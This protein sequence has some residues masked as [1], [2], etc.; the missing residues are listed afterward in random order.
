[1][2]NRP[3]EYMNRVDFIYKI[4]SNLLV[5]NLSM[6]YIE[7]E[8]GKIKAFHPVDGKNYQVLQD[9]K[10][11]LYISFQLSNSSNEYLLPYQELIIL[12]KFYY[13]KGL[14]GNSNKVLNDILETQE[15]TNQGIK[16]GIQLS[17]SIKGI[18][19]L[20]GMFNDVD[21]EEYK[22]NFLNSI[23]D[24]TTNKSKGGIAVTDARGEFKETELKPIIL[25]KE[26]MDKVEGDIYKYFGI[27][28]KIIESNFN[29]EQWTSF[30]RSVIEPLS[31]MLS[32][33][34]TNKIFRKESILEGNRIVFTSNL[35]HYSSIENKIKLIKETASLGIFTKDEIRELINYDPLEDKN[36]GSRILQTLN[37]I[38]AAIANDYQLGKK[39]VKEDGKQGTK[40]EE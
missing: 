10:G 21:K 31:I 27:N 37:N 3:N 18:L 25:H 32:N 24:M 30:Y 2:N 13:G 40:K 39:G 15:I 23:M 38:D 33:E 12:R 1:M 7:K 5:E 9:S 8:E 20:N 29:E 17:N 28:S 4:V 11:D 22:K 34:F 35:I 14:P 16:N 19:K 26:Q 6:I 36:E